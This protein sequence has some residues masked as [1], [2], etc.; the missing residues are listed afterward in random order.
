MLTKT[1]VNSDIESQLLNI[2][3]T[4]GIGN[5]SWKKALRKYNRLIAEERL[6]YFLNKYSSP[7]VA[8]LCNQ[9]ANVLKFKL[10]QVLSEKGVVTL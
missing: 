4:R 2:L 5:A 1:L 3:K 9:R 6:Y 7:N 8:E 10:N